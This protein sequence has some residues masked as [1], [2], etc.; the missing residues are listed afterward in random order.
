MKVVAMATTTG[1]RNPDARV[2]GK[3]HDLLRTNRNAHPNPYSRIVIRS[4]SHPVLRS[5]AYGTQPNGFGSA[6]SA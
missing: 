4:L 1:L 3:N 6:Y 2:R 5:K